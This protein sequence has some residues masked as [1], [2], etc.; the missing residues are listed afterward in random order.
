MPSKPL[1][2]FGSISNSLVKSCI[3]NP[4]AIYIRDYQFDLV[5]YSGHVVPWSRSTRNANDPKEYQILLLNENV[6][7][8]APRLR[9]LRVDHTHCS[10]LHQL[11]LDS[12][13]CYAF[14]EKSREYRDPI[15]STNG[16]QYDYTPPEETAAL[17]LSNIF[18][19]YD[20][21]GFIYHFSPLKN[22]NDEKLI[23]LKNDLWLNIST[24]AIFLEFIYY[25]PNTDLLT[26]IN[27]LFEFLTTGKA[28]VIFIR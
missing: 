28:C 6:I 19:P 17:E 7:I 25:N 12:T 15:V 21:G 5:S 20:T 9:Q 23:E 22:L 18:G 4:Y 14:Y 1:I 24:R 3:V 10:T 8:G 16:H 13:H 2:N 26:S 11:H 27:I